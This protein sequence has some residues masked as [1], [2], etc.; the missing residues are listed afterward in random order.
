[1][2]YI[3]MSAK[4]RDDDNGWMD[5]WMDLEKANLSHLYCTNGMCCDP[6]SVLVL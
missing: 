4:V 3:C 5:G 1:M 2:N 6:P